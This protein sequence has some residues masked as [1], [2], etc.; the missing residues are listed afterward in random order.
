MQVR[1]GVGMKVVDGTLQRKQPLAKLPAKAP[2]SA[3]KTNIGPPGSISSAT[4]I[5]AAA[6]GGGD[7]ARMTPEFVRLRPALYVAAWAAMVQASASEVDAS[8]DVAPAFVQVCCAV[9]YCL[10]RRCEFGCVTMYVLPVF[11]L[12]VLLVSVV[13]IVWC[14]CFLV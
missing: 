14:L 11:R 13:L 3:G 10:A 1:A 7:A 12:L 8:G 9:L 4:A 6:A 5:A 2:I